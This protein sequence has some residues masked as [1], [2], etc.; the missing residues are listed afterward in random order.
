MKAPRT[1]RTR[2]DASLLIRCVM[3]AVDALAP[4]LRAAG[5]DVARV[6][7]LLE[8][9]L[10]LDLNP[11]ARDGGGMGFAIGIVLS[12][13]AF[14]MLGIIAG[15]IG[16]TMKRAD[17]WI[18]LGQGLHLFQL[19]M[20]LFAQHG[21]LLVDRTDLA[22]AAPRPV[23]ERT[24][25]AARLLHLSVYVV[26]LS[27]ASAFF[28]SVLGAFEFGA[29]RALVLYP[30]LTLCSSLL[31]VGAL[32]LAFALALRAFG[33]QRFQRATFW[34]QIL[35][36]SAAPFFGIA[37]SRGM[38]FGGD[39]LPARALEPLL[40]LAPPWHQIGL[41]ECTRGALD[42]QHL[43]RAALALA[44]PLLGML[45]TL[46][47]ASRHFVLALLAGDEA[48]GAGRGQSGWSAPPLARALA[49]IA[50]GATERAGSGFAHA[51]LWRE[52]T[53]VRAFLPQAFSLSMT[54]LLFSLPRRRSGAASMQDWSHAGLLML[55][56]LVPCA[57]E[58]ARFS[59]H[60]GARWIL[61]A[62]PIRE[63]K[64][65]LRGNLR[66]LLVAGVAPAMLAMGAL[67]WLVRGGD[68][69]LEIGYALLLAF[70]AGLQLATRLDVDLL[71]T[72]Q[73]NPNAANWK[74]SGVIFG[75]ML[76]V[77]FVLAPFLIA[78]CLHPLAEAA[79]IALTAFAAWDG[80]RRCMRIAP[81]ALRALD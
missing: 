49:R 10:L 20:L 54:A 45:V 41:Y 5:V 69:A 59:E 19:G 70:A 63:A 43:A 21:A 57:F 71:F 26:L 23:S 32:G 62:A 16:L 40:W 1:W 4:F 61:K 51:L 65:L 73:A 38:S 66:A 78:T 39:A 80:W 77:I 25:F 47:L 30:L 75:G 72:V 12:M 48:G 18:G 76:L 79:G 58:M 28:P 60:A 3:R 29:L 31:A 14:S 17:V 22:L 37:V 33:P 56:L 24:V 11:L 36:A 2:A 67:V 81:L 46:R 64:Q 52:R 42:A 27:C 74:N 35:A 9:R 34:L 6:K 55:M 53:F 44:L 68:G 7:V 50:H 8:T 15:V 13:L